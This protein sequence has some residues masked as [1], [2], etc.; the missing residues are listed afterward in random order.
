MPWARWRAQQHRSATV[1][2]P[3]LARACTRQAGR[4]G[5]GKRSRGPA[6]PWL[7]CP[8]RSAARP[9]P[10]AAEKGGGVSA[11]AAAG[12][13]AQGGGRVMARPPRAPRRSVRRPHTCL[14]SQL[15]IVADAMDGF[16]AQHARS[17]AAPGG[18]LSAG[19][20]MGGFFSVRS[21]FISFFFFSLCSRQSHSLRAP[22]VLAWRRASARVGRVPPTQPRARRGASPTRDEGTRSR[23]KGAR[24]LR[25]LPP[26]GDREGPEPGWLTD[27]H[28]RPRRTL[29]FST[30]PTR[31][32]C[33]RAGPSQGDHQRAPAL[34]QCV[35]KGVRP[36]APHRA[37]LP[38]DRAMRARP[39]PCPLRLQRVG[40]TRA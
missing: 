6:Q 1:C 39:L 13:A 20:L 5:P 16:S 12:A 18:V 8:T 28:R 14:S 31:A 9:R 33:L 27:K 7:R 2:S 30:L 25:A 17:A 34:E 22:D 3:R 36:P 40:A 23:P 38:P 10:P 24:D 15:S 37:R 11:A 19:Q 35:R 21:L 29:A 4:H 32:P 26:P